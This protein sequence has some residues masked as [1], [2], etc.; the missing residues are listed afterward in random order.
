MS[1]G[2]EPAAGQSGDLVLCKLKHWSPA[3]SDV[4]M[5]P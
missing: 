2:T 1:P 4:T 3:L 5:E